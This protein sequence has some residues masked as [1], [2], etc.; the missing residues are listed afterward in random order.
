MK[1]EPGQKIGKGQRA[2]Q[3]GFQQIKAI[4]KKRKLGVS[5][6]LGVQLELQRITIEIAKRK[7][8]IGTEM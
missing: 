3:T 1:I 8:I 4:R 2:R 6:I 7:F 5:M